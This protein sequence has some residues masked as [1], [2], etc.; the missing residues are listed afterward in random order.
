[1]Q[2]LVKGLRANAKDALHRVP[3]EL[4]HYL[5]ERILVSNWYPEEDHLALLR[6]FGKATGLGPEGSYIPFGHFLAQFELGGVYRG[7]LH[8]GNLDR[9]FRAFVK[10][11]P[12]NHDTG[13]LEFTP[14]RRGY[15]L[16][17]TGYALV[18]HEICDI[19]TG[20]MDEA[21]RMVGAAP[22]WVHHTKCR[23]HGAPVCVW[24][25]TFKD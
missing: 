3:E 15:T 12:Q 21:V 20:Y 18:A 9:T 6:I 16:T 13:T 24:E 11:W 8:V 5:E 17:L 1:M 19:V 4:R 22:A 10:L 25:I 7:S 2:P 14:K 23:T